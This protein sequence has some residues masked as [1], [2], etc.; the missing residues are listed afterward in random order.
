M[1]GPTVPQPF[2]L[3]QS[4][5]TVRGDAGGSD[6]AATAGDGAGGGDKMTFAER[7]NRLEN[8][9]SLRFYFFNFIFSPP[10]MR[11]YLVWLNIL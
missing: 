4:N 2:R 6:A 9:V 10:L 7:M 3:S 8:K 5:R 11:H 1:K